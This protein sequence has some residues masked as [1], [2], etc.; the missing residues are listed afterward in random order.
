M[1]EPTEVSMNIVRAR[2][3]MAMNKLYV[4]NGGLLSSLEFIMEIDREIIAIWKSAPWYLQLE[5]DGNDP[6][7]PLTHDYAHWQHHLLH[8]FTCV[9]RIR[10]YRPFLLSRN[11]SEPARTI[12]IEAAGS[13]L[14]VY[15]ALR[16]KKGDSLLKSHRFISQNYQI[17]STAL[18]LAV[19]LLVERPSQPHL[20]RSD[21]E[22]AISDLE[23]LQE[24]GTA[25]PMA[26]DGVRVLRKFLEM[27]DYRGRDVDSESASLVPAIYSIIGGKATTGKY[28]ERCK[29]AINTNNSAELPG[30]F[31]SGP[32]EPQMPS[33]PASSV[34]QD[35]PSAAILGDLTNFDYNNIM[36]FELP[37][38]HSFWEQ[39][40][41]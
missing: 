20:I 7:L 30:T 28:L 12:C 2:L 18:T 37:P 21:I 23:S 8:T 6:E 40:D 3:I 25:I 22:M 39:W 17:F 1:D 31:G 41:F 5:I 4:K 11:N 27:Y 16:R 9:Q 36:N 14:S 32:S 19:L 15:R 35:I 33:P 29:N 26:M 24:R 13:A 34:E 10:M 38:D